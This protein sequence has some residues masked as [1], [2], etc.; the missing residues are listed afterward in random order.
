MPWETREI[1][2]AGRLVTPGELQAQRTVEKNTAVEKRPVLGWNAYVEEHLADLIEE[3]PTAV[4][5][6]AA[7]AGALSGG[8]WPVAPK[9]LREW[10][11]QRW[12][13]VVSGGGDQ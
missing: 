10:Y 1:T 6:L 5:V 3:W 2:P 8:G 12:A 7:H 13:P 11:E 4:H 9:V